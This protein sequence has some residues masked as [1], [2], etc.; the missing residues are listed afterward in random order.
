[1]QIERSIAE[2][3]KW[4][5]PSENVMSP[6]VPRLAPRFAG[7]RLAV[8]MGLAGV[9]AVT[10]PHP[11]SAESARDQSPQVTVSY[12]PKR[13]E[14]TYVGD[15]VCNSCHQ[16]KVRAYHRTAHAITSSVPSQDSIRGNFSPGSNILPTGNPDL[17]FKMEASE[18]GFFQTA[19]LRTSPS[20]AYNRTERFDVVVGSGRKGQTYLFW[21]GDQLF[22]LP[23][24]YGTELG[25]WMNSPGYPDGSAYF[26]R[27]ITP[28]CLECHV[29]SF[30]SVAPPINRFN[31]ASFLLGISCERCH[32]PGSEHVARYRSKTPPR[33]PS[34]AAII[35]PAR[36]S[37]DRQMDLCTLC[38]GGEG[39]SILPALSFVVGDV[40]D[41]FVSLPELPRDAPVD[42]HGSQTQF[43]VR[44]RCF[45]SS[46]A[47]TCTT[48]HDVH[49]PRPDLTAYAA[50]CL[51]CHKVESCGVFPKLGHRI[52]RQCVA[53][54]MPLQLTGRML[55]RIDRKSVQ[56]KAHNHRIAI[57]PDSQL[58]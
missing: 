14:K 17:Y 9:L 13:S 58:P 25:G 37:R 3:Q 31:K 44:S 42:P 8:W 10:G 20:M 46:P 32:G 48:C 54:H 57:Y 43:F 56:L 23:V 35:N 15:E 36:L 18:K 29:S 45:Q 24:S 53:C 38:H 50:R 27:P 2:T 39:E 16:D 33:S 52:D 1:M 4:A 47:M 26:E 5:M 28:R 49:A 11:V 55:V 30:E 41:R 12:Q 6:S 34:E 22:Q 40:L 21:D 7:G 51:S 19:W